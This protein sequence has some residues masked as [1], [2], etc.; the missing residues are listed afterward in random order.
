MHAAAIVLTLVEFY[1]AMRIVGVIL[2]LVSAIYAHWQQNLRSAKAVK[3]LYINTQGQSFVQ[4]NRANNELPAR[5]LPQSMVSP[6]FCLL[7]W[8]IEQET[9]Y[10]LVLPDMLDKTAFRRLRVWAKFHP[11]HKNTNTLN[12]I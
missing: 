7:T 12:R 3:R 5:L 6:Y 10:Q 4:L 2:L 11:H 1:G 8:Q 9:I